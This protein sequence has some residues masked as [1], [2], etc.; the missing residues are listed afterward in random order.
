MLTSAASVP[1]LQAARTSVKG[2]E[3]LHGYKVCF[4]TTRLEK[5]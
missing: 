4:E 1:F 5:P 3:H 2:Y